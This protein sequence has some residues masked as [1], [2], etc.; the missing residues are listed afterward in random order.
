MEF[1]PVIGLEIHSQLLT[2]TKIFCGCSAKFGAAP[3]TQGCPV[4]LGLPGALPVLNR[5][6]VEYAI[7]AALALECDILKTSV[8]ARKNYFY[9]DLPK[10]YQI[11]QYA[12]PLAANGNL[13][14]PQ[15]NQR[16]GITRIHLEEDA[17]KS[18]HSGFSDS[19]RKSY[20]D[21]NRSG[22]P[23]IE[24][25][26]EPDL[27]SARQAY[28]FFS[29]LREILVAIGVNDGNM[30][31]GSIRCD[32][33]VSV[34]PV[35]QAALGVK[36]EVKNLNSFRFVERAIEFEIDRQITE[37]KKGRLVIQETRLWDTDRGQTFLMRSKE[38]AHDYRYF[39]EPDLPPL[40]VT[41]KW[42]KEIGESLPE[43]PEVKREQ[44]VSQY[45]LTRDQAMQLT[46]VRPGLD[47]YFK[48]L[49]ER[50]ENSRG[51]INWTLGEI[52]R[53]M[54]DCGIEDVKK[55]EDKVSPEALAELIMLVDRGTISMKIAKDVFDTMYDTGQSAEQIVE[56][57]GLSQIDNEADLKVV[58]VDIVS[59]HGKVVEQYRAG[60]TSAL[61][62]LIGKVM[63]ATKGKANPKLANKLLRETIDN[64]ES[65]T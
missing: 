20:I 62:F 18:L 13:I 41:E 1:E 39:S 6:A 44:L 60:K 45:G 27:R 57:G 59:H 43:L 31:E 8:F 63:S 24:I 16:I 40:K 47:S 21:L 14:D 29:A 52:N 49:A 48:Q 50:T 3:N 54:N 22:V 46:R 2:H 61:G 19:G 58:V 55:I 5:T 53:K 10:G 28:E 33:N 36:I 37:L 7:K 42:I 23:L 26:T 64:E 56:T 15:N 32:A 25:V 51:S 11:S 38:E 35:G 30:E 12:L 34:R 9:P 65:V 4:C 17:G